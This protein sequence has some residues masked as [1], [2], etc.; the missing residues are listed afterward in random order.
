MA[1]PFRILVAEDDESFL[2]AIA[3]L[4][5]QDDRFT[6]AGRACD[7]RQAV[8][9]AERL[10]PDAVVMDIEMPVLD[11]V[12]A[13]TLLRAAAP[14]LPIVAVSGHDYEE[15]VLEIRL[16]GADDYVRKA[17]LADEL[18]RVLAALLERRARSGS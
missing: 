9:L 18:P 5:E 8:A 17:R 3:L 15:R 12:E 10:S 6:V 13:T 11:G 4:L 7:G 1:I 2:D 16:A 14:Q